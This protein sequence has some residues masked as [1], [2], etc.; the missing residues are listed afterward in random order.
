ML[1]N[2]LPAPSITTTPIIPANN[3]YINKFINYI[4]TLGFMGVG[5]SIPPTLKSSMLSSSNSINV[6]DNMSNAN[7]KD[8]LHP[9]NVNSN[10][11]VIYSINSNYE[12]LDY[13]CKYLTDPIKYYGYVDTLWNDLNVKDDIVSVLLNSNEYN[14]CNKLLLDQDNIIYDKIDVDT[15]NDMIKKNDYNISRCYFNKYSN[16]FKLQ[17]FKDNCNYM[18]FNY[19]NV[20]DN[21][22]FK[23]KFVSY[24]QLDKYKLIDFINQ[25]YQYM[26]KTF[27]VNL[28]V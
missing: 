15:L 3:S 16:N 24:S 28:I 22:L 8:V 14:K 5:E 20:L 27:I 23:N 19:E 9:N 6:T 2:N 7:N 18:A 26:D 12:L 1:N 17:Q 10:I 13:K 21:T 4:N 25:Y 11:D